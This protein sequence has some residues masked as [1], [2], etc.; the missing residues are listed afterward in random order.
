MYPEPG[1]CLFGFP[2]PRQP[3]AEAAVTRGQGVTPKQRQKLPRLF[4][5]T[6]GTSPPP[7]PAEPTRPFS[8]F[9]GCGFV[10]FGWDCDR[11]CAGPQW[12]PPPSSRLLSFFSRGRKVLACAIKPSSHLLWPLISFFFGNFIEMSLYFACHLSLF[13]LNKGLLNGLIAPS[14]GSSL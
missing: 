13:L 9:C 2:E 4:L 5:Q 10:E 1:A 8:S 14:V 6:D 12:P 7:A 11:Q 3:K